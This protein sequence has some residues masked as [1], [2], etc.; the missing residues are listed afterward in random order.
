MELEQVTKLVRGSQ[1]ERL[2]LATKL[3]FDARRRVKEGDLSVFLLPLI[4]AIVK[5]GLV[6]PISDIPIVGQ[7]LDILL[8][9]PIAVYLFIF[10]W[11]RGKWK[12]RVLFFFVSLLDIVPIIDL[13][14]FTTV[15]V[16]YARHLAKEA[17][18]AAR[19]EL[20]KLDATMRGLSRKEQI[21]LQ[22]ARMEAEQ[23][24]AMRAEAKVTQGGSAPEMNREGMALGN[25][26][27]AGV[28][29][30]LSTA[31]SLPKTKGMDVAQ[32]GMTLAKNE[33]APQG[34]KNIPGTE[35]TLGGSMGERGAGSAAI[36]SMGTSHSPEAYAFSK[37]YSPLQ[38]QKL[39]E[40]IIGARTPMADGTYQRIPIGYG[41]KNEQIQRGEKI[42]D[43][44]QQVT[45]IDEK[46]QDPTNAAELAALQGKLGVA[47]GIRRSDLG[48]IM[49][50][51]QIAEQALEKHKNSIL[52]KVSTF[53][54]RDQKSGNLE[55]VVELKK[56][57]FESRAEDYR[58]R[59]KLLEDQISGIKRS[60]EYNLSQKEALLAEIDK[61]SGEMEEQK[62][63]WKAQIQEFYKNQ[64][65]A[66]LD[67]Q[68]SVPD[69]QIGKYMEED[70]T[71]FLHSVPLGGAPMGNTAQNNTT[72]DTVNM[73]GGDKIRILT[74]LEPTISVSALKRPDQS[75]MYATGVVLNQ[76]EIHSAYDEDAATIN[77]G[78][79]V[80]T[81][82]YESQRGVSSIQGN[83]AE[84][85][86]R[87]INKKSV[88]G[89]NELVIG[90]PRVGAVFV[91]TDPTAIVDRNGLKEAADLSAELGV[92]L[93]HIEKDG[94]ARDLVTGEKVSPADL[95]KKG[96]VTMSTERR[97]K[98]VEEV[99]D[100]AQTG[101]KDK[102]RMFERVANLP[103]GE[104]QSSEK[105]TL[106]SLLD[107][108]P[109]LVEIVSGRLR[110]ESIGD[111]MREYQPGKEILDADTG[112]PV[113]TM[114]KEWM[115]TLTAVAERPD[116]KVAISRVDRMNKKIEKRFENK[117]L[118]IF[119]E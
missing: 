60:G 25:A 73:A 55:A 18:D 62:R 15:C 67:Y 10:M 90:S 56:Q 48:E 1:I 9:F 78:M 8:S 93:L 89:W 53:L 69:R 46:L 22:R 32:G 57:Q 112:L 77:Y 29:Q 50:E 3:A 58:G 52:G 108:P 79:D 114:K 16:L 44:R 110:K 105:T 51:R 4:V 103:S 82:K 106:R 116:L 14:P 94:S 119:G 66:L 65:E 74:A 113:A 30:S 98:I 111:V 88:G 2:K 6:D 59:E 101:E 84:E 61:L 91:R 40:R 27:M 37:K 31:T 11:G 97:K 95:T 99:L 117:E 115:E 38:R 49:Q 41:G 68:E 87:V 81:A 85:T 33:A 34:R 12:M 118:D 20:A 24:T 43:L 39:A 47:Q 109:R 70:N 96:S 23:E 45:D 75:T 86:R 72:L 17:A 5:D 71:W 64:G 76:G 100:K 36:N 104:H 35:G 80:R 83:I 21:E 92:P 19:D 42:I 26:M 107:L 54:G 102:K 13:I 63:R 7:I 28:S